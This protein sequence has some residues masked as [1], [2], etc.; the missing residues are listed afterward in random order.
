MPRDPRRYYAAH[1]VTSR[2]V[3]RDIADAGQSMLLASDVKKIS[4]AGGDPTILAEAVVGSVE[5][6]CVECGRQEDGA[7]PNS[8]GD[9]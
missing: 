8:T 6:P 9:V 4:T 3:G 2:T 7:R 1:Q 5:L